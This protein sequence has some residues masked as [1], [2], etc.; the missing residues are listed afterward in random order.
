MSS[1][2]LTFPHQE[3][4]EKLRG[5]FAGGRLTLYL[6]AGVS[7]A[8]GLPSWQTLVATL[9]YKAISDDWAQA[10]KPYPNYLFAMAE[11]F[12]RQSG[13][14]PEV[15]AGKVESYYR[16]A[17]GGQ[18]STD[19]VRDL[20]NILYAPWLLPDGAIHPPPV[21]DMRMGNP[22]LD[23][24]AQLCNATTDSRGLYNVVTTNYDDLLERALSA[25][26]TGA[27][28]Q[29]A[30]KSSSFPA[31][32]GR[33]GS[34]VK[35]I[36]HVHGYLPSGTPPADSTSHG[37]IFT[38]ADYLDAAND[39]YSWS[40]LCLLRCFSSSVGLVLGMSMTDRNLRR[41][42][43]ALNGAQMLDDVYIILR[44]ASLPTLT[45]EDVQQIQNKARSYLDRFQ[46]SGVKGEWHV[47]RDIDK[48]L[49]NLFSQ[50]QV[51]VEGTLRDFGLK[52]IWISNHAEIPPILDAIRTTA[53]N[54]AIS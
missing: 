41:L 3:A 44:K 14:P 13:E 48:I 49:T 7:L 5:A 24:I 26:P 28:F 12:V 23:A 4:I 2:A 42:L 19:F 11:W 29:S 35:G 47:H 33:A 40:N 25:G 16:A 1:D 15:V 21:S 38:E 31:D 20:F 32:A 46:Q 27:S 37:I 22:L 34:A 9:Y 54:R 30:W 45:P 53:K 51:I 39:L 17:N 36:F 10:W 6:G 50:E 52:P 18:V 8:S 43:H